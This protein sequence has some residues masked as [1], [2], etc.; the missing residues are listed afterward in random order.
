VFSYSFILTDMQIDTTTAAAE[1]DA[2]SPAAHRH[3]GTVQQANTARRHATC[4][5][6]TRVNTAAGDNSCSQ[7][8]LAALRAT[9]RQDHSRTLATDDLG[10][11]V[12][13][14]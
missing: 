12:I 6:V 13:W 1:I 2:R 11:N 4:P 7:P 3:R 14:V 9:T 10:L 5:P 8:D